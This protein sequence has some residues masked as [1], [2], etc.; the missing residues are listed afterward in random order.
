MN[1]YIGFRVQET[2]QTVQQY[3]QL[4]PK[5]RTLILP[6]V[7]VAATDVIHILEYL[8]GKRFASYLELSEQVHQTAKYTKYFCETYLSYFDVSFQENGCQLN[9]KP[10]A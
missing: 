8:E 5:A 6:I 7:N 1:D 9:Q 2:G 10:T 3:F 4:S